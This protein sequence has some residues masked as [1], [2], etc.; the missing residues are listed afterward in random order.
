M[1]TQTCE[2]LAARIESD[3]V[4]LSTLREPDQQGWTRQVFSEPYRSSRDLVATK[5]RRCGLEVHTDAA[6]NIVGV[7]RGSSPGAPALVTGSHTDTV[8]GGGRFDG[9]VGVVGAL[10]L[11]RQ[12]RENDITLTRDLIVV[13][14]LGEESN[15]WGL[16]CLGSRSLAGELTAA[17][18]ERRDGQGLR[19]G[20]R[21]H[22]FGLDP[23]SVMSA[24]WLRDIPLHS[25]VELHVEQG[26][27][28]EQHGTQ[29]G[30]VTAIAG[31]ERMLATFVGRPDHAGT[32][33]MDDRKDA[34]VAAAR[35]VLTVQ[36][37]GCGAPKHGVATTTRLAN[38][39]ASPN[40]VPGEVQMR[41]E[42]RSID[43]EW[44]SL[45]KK[46]IVADVVDEARR[47][48]V[49]VEFEWTTDNEIVRAAPQIQNVVAMSAEQSGL[50]WQAVPSGA[51][52]DAVHLA[53]L[54][55]MGMIFVPSRE[56][57]SHCPEEWTDV[58]DIAAGVQV[59][60][61]TITAL[62]AAD[63]VSSA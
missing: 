26:P 34:M 9:I 17:D 51:T 5:M 13:D 32:R 59:L 54:C 41:T 4:E 63:S 56:G 61:T 23:S 14:F 46:Q 40:V 21:Y 3:I 45:A 19:L 8:T 31:I 62:D 57:R 47:E 27:L 1:S 50:S 25:Y 20:D 7:L 24:D 42:F 58:A 11:V 22:A 43:S 16:S 55:P 52:H 18:L 38:G 53:R 2:P 39:V 15:D 60:S 35:A 37:I 29:I 48:G 12:L 10:E 6:G 33:P 36:R 49:D 44:L 28:L 30:V